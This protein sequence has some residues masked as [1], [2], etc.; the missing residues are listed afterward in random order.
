MCFF[1]FF[2]NILTGITAAHGLSDIACIFIFGCCLVTKIVRL[3]C[4]PMDSS[5]LLPGSSIHGIFQARILEWVAIS[6]PGDLPHS[7]IE[8]TSPK[9]VGGFFTTEPPG[10]PIYE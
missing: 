8:L 2:F 3:I 6:F 5:P 7:R 10:K 1:F 4:D 9:L